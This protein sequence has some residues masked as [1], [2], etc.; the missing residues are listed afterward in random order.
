MI[1]HRKSCH[2]PHTSSHFKNQ[3]RCFADAALQATAYHKNW[4]NNVGEHSCNF[5]GACKELLQKF[6]AEEEQKRNFMVK[7]E[8]A[9]D[10]AAEEA[11]E[12]EEVREV[13]EVLAGA[14]DEAE[15]EEFLKTGVLSVGEDEALDLVQLLAATL[16][17]RRVLKLWGSRFHEAP[18]KRGVRYGIKVQT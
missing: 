2:R 14:E 9:L 4:V 1:C 6:I 18:C 11:L 8:R 5:R 16:T 7:F 3:A 17:T 10:Q 12:D 15:V 13:L